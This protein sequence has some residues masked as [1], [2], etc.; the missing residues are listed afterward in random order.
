M[1]RRIS[2][3]PAAPSLLLA[4]LLVPG[5]GRAQ[6]PTLGFALGESS[7]AQGG[8]AAVP[9]T[10]TSDSEVQGL[11]A[12]MDW[13][14]G[15]LAGEELIPGAAI[16]DAD[17]MTVRVE[18]AYAVLGV[19]IDSDGTGDNFIP[20]G[21][22]LDLGSLRVRCL[23]GAAG[24]VTV[25]IL[26]TEDGAG[27]PSVEGGPALDNIV[28]VGGLS[29]GREQGL[30]LT[31]GQVTCLEAARATF[32]IES[33]TADAA[34][35]CGEVR[36]LMDNPVDAVEGYVVSV[37]HPASL[38]LDGISIVG[39]AAEE[40]GADF[41][42]ADTL[43]DG[44]TLGVV[45]DLVPPFDGNTIPP[46]EDRAIAVYSYCCLERP[47]EGEPPA[48]AT[49]S[50]SDGLGSPPK[51]NSVVTGGESVLPS[52]IDGTFT[53][54]PGGDEPDVGNQ[55]VACGTEELAE[56]GLPY[57]PVGSLGRD[58][59]VCFFYKS[60]QIGL[61]PGE[62]AQV[63]GLSLA[64]CYP[65]ELEGQEGSFNV[66]GTIVEAVGAEFI[67]HQ[68]DN[69]P[70]DGDGCE[71]VLGILV[72]AMPPFDGATLPPTEE[73]LRI[74]CSR[75][76]IADDPGLCGQCLSLEFCDGINGRGIVP[77]YN[78]ASVDSQPRGLRVIG[79]EVCLEDK[80]TFH[81][82]DCNFSGNGIRAV[83]IA[84]AAATISYLFLEGALQ[85]Q[86]PCLDA[87]DTNDDGRIDLGDA[88]YLLN[89]LFVF[90]PFPP[91][92]G[93]GFAPDGTPLPPGED[94]TLDDLG[95]AE[96]GSC[97]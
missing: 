79:C 27:Y 89:F 84:D 61:P 83:E 3:L 7:A 47:A 26:F 56:D 90:G 48:V 2:P 23:V 66:D 68:V 34:T 59:D 24:E 85:F 71:M 53:C 65:C 38:S 49:L 67:S 42:Q 93:P 33:A 87:C 37:A 75:F 13:D 36:I 9:L 41:H 39:T 16:A 44:G 35:G 76:T 28:T 91:D 25:P 64:L 70:S 63:Q 32:E 22:G 74:G 12:V 31:D 86:P 20:P 43:A 29:I 46:G 55:T 94:P 97:S 57:T 77:V 18:D 96:G 1:Y 62:I 51:E 4:L 60:P 69:D 14:G 17:L 78:L 72:D 30:V 54:P 21:E 6:D 92:P 50:F 11:V 45:M 8:V 81:R 5:I 95:C 15:S 88:S 19:V 80:K 40:Y 82:G 58:V 52:T 10:L 73:Y